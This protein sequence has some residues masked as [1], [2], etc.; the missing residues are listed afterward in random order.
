M[1]QDDGQAPTILITL[2]ERREKALAELELERDVEQPDA[3][4]ESVR[5]VDPLG[6][7]AA[8]TGLQRL[9]GKSL[10]DIVGGR[11]VLDQIGRSAFENVDRSVFDTVAK[12]AFANMD[13]SAFDGIGRGVAGAMELGMVGQRA[14]ELGRVG[15]KLGEL[16]A[17]VDGLT[18]ASRGVAAATQVRPLLETP[19]PRVLP[20]SPAPAPE[21]DLD[22][23]VIERPEVNLL[24]QLIGVQEAQVELLRAM[25][26]GQEAEASRGEARDRRADERDRRAHRSQRATFVVAVEA[27][28]VSAVVAGGHLSAGPLTGLAVGSLGVGLAVWWDWQP[29]R[30]CWTRLRQWRP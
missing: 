24:Q 21:L 10:L 2:K 14:M 12:S 9:A 1:T 3:A 26:A 22:D 20:A 29:A 28:V 30:R 18:A 8:F 19:M 15:E 17:R 27:V 16:T 25:T 4:S 7:A 13:R 6:A 5:V 11:G 23:L